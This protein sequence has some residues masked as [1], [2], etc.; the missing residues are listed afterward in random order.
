MGNPYIIEFKV[1]K[2]FEDLVE[3]IISAIERSINDVKSLQEPERLLNKLLHQ[4]EFFGKMVIH[5]RSSEKIKRVELG[6][7]HWIQRRA[8]QVKSRIEKILDDD[9][10]PWNKS[11]AQEFVT[12][13]TESLKELRDMQVIERKVIKGVYH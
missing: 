2:H 5:D 13:L 1:T 7:T 3:D 9:R 12:E 8:F 4:L 11:V 6:R 10:V